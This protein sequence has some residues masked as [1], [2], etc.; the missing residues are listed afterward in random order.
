[1]YMIFGRHKNAKLEANHWVYDMFLFVTLIIKIVYVVTALKNRLDPNDRNQYIMILAQ[2]LFTMLICFLMLYL[3]HPYSVH[4]TEIWRDTKIFLFMYAILTLFD[5]DWNLFFSPVSAV[6][7]DERRVYN[8]NRAMAQS[9]SKVETAMH[10]LVC[11]KGSV[12]SSPVLDV[13]PLRAFCSDPQI[14][15]GTVATLVVVVIILVLGA[16]HKRKSEA[17]HYYATAYFI[18]AATIAFAFW[19]H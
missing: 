11:N 18:L 7:S 12:Y 2:N 10:G 9:R 15:S 8:T 13:A 16:I 17:R 19:T 3:F 6:I 4:P 14:G 5:I 1:M